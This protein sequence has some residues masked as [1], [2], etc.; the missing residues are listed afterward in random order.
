M[1]AQEQEIDL[2]LF[3]HIF[4]DPHLQGTQDL[5]GQPYLHAMRFFLKYLETRTEPHLKK[6]T[7]K[8]KK[9]IEYQVEIRSLKNEQDL[10]NFA[11]KIQKDITGLTPLTDSIVIPGGWIGI[12]GHAMLYEFKKDALGNL[13]FLIHNTGAGIEHH[14]QIE[15]LDKPRCSSVKAYIIPKESLGN[16]DEL[17]CG[18]IKQIIRPMQNLQIS[19]DSDELYLEIFPQ[20]IFLNGQECDPIAQNHIRREQAT[21][22]QI[23]GTCTQKV[24][25]QM[26]ELSFPDKKS[27]KRFIYD[28][29]K[30]ALEQYI[31]EVKSKGLIEQDGVRNQISLA[32]ESIARTLSSPKNKDYF[33]IL[34]KE[35]ALKWLQQHQEEF[36][37]VAPVI[38]VQEAIDKY[39]STHRL[40]NPNIGSTFTIL[41]T[42]KAKYPSPDTVVTLKAT[43]AERPVLFDFHSSKVNHIEL[44]KFLSDVA[45]LQSSDPFA[46]LLSLEDF[47]IKC[48]ITKFE[49]HSYQI[50]SKLN[51]IY[52][53]SYKKTHGEEKI[54]PNFQVA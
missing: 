33:T 3:A 17:L 50:I 6:L 11:K 30:F 10:S 22:G 14:Q 21:A 43:T 40:T 37:R 20:I 48:P 32:I 1:P 16:P 13:V 34:E 28:F 45:K 49:E 38:A 5:E 26:S 51:Q 15:S 46:A 9:L 12:S 4:N 7:E 29:E 52:L 36:Q 53:D 24:L 2:K 23:T 25:K 19:H 41:S 8:F 35:E 31:Q 42:K 39:S 44:S 47:F 18:F 54:T 27:Y